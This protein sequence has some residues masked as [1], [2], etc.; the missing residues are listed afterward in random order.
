MLMIKFAAEISKTR[1]CGDGE[2][3]FL[4]WLLFG[5]IEKNIREVRFCSKYCAFN[6]A[7]SFMMGA[8][9]RTAQKK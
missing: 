6:L 8:M 5:E 9:R 7:K 1:R 2:N 3:L 4:S